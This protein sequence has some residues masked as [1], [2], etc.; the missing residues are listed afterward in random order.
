MAGTSKG[1]SRAGV[2]LTNLDQ[3]LFDGADATKRDL[4]DYLDGVRDLILPELE[5]RP[6]SVIRVHRGQEAFMQKNVPKYTPDWVP[7]VQLWAEASKR[8]VVVRAVQ[9]PAHAA[10]VRQS[11]RG[12][13][14]PDAHHRRAAR[15]RHPPGA[16]PR[17]A[18]G[19]R[20]RDGGRG[21]APRTAGARRRRIARRGQDEWCEGS[22]RV[23]PR[24]RRVAPRGLGCR[25]P[26]HRHPRGRP[27][28]RHRHHCVH[29]GGPRGQGVRRFHA[30]GRRDRR[31]RLQPAG[32]ARGAGVVPG[33]VGRAGPHRSRRLHRPHR[34]RTAGGS[35]ARGT[36]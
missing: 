36:T 16:R 34:A 4:V 1:E 3:S 19:G 17:P 27:G 9:R 7:T 15:P 21:G 28:P 10:V 35:D 23:R 6:L 22:A 13:V 29:Q 31:Q 12:R 8:E 2:P 18:G 32:A 25:H 5:E 24:R 33:G 20:V 11:A 26:C 30:G 14:P